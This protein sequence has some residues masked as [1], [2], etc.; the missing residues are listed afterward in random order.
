MTNTAHN[1]ATA[2]KKP[3]HIAY[4]IRETGPDESF[5]T[6]IGA[7]WPNADGEGFN[8]QIDLVPLDRRLSIRTP[9]EKKK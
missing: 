7:A 4:P 5:W 1:E 3:S 9:F 2:S 8:I 6:R